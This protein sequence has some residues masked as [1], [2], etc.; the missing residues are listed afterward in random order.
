MERGVGLPIHSAV[1]VALGAVILDGQDLEA[2]ADLAEE[3]NRWE[4]MVTGAPLN[5][6]AGGGSSINV[7]ATF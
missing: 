7:L 4:F 6:K 2:V 5:I 1:L 3:L